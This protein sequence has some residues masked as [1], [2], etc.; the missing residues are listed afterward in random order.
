MPTVFIVLA[1]RRCLG[2]AAAALLAACARQPAPPAAAAARAAAASATAPPALAPV[3]SAYAE[4]RYLRDRFDITTATGQAA[5]PDGEPLVTLA[6]RFNAM[7]RALA[8][9][10]AAVDAGGLGA[11]DRRALDV[12]RGTFERDLGEL[13]DAP[14]ADDGVDASPPDCAYDARA[15]ASASNGL[16]S[17]TRRVYAC[18]GWAQHHVMLDGERMDR[19]TVLSALARTDDRARRRRLFL[20]LDPVWRSVNGDN[21][22]ASPFRQLVALA[23]RRRGAAEPPAAARA[24]GLGVHPDSMERWLLAMLETWRASTPDSLLEPWD[25]HYMGGRASRVLSPKLPPARLTNLN[26]EVFRALGADVDSLRVHY[27]LAPREGKTPVAFTTFGARAGP[28]GGAW[29]PAE[30]WVFATYRAGGLDN[31]NELLH[32]TGHA[33]HIAAVRTRPAF[34]DWPDS[35][36]FTEG[37]ADFIALDAYE[38]A[39]QQRWLGDSVP[40]ADGLRGRYA[41]V[42]LDVAWALFEVRMQRDP[43]ADPNQVWTAITRDYLKIRPHPELSWWAMRGQLVNSPGYMMNYAIGSILIAA[44][45]A[46]TRELHG[47]FA[48]GD[49]TWYAWVAPRLFRFGLER[50]SREVLEEFLGG[51]LSPTAILADM[52]RMQRMQRTQGAGTRGPAEAQP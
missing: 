25:W 38:P 41:G 19:L 37:L 7:R 2:V 3:E 29:A 42:V 31:L 21:G 16:D 22:A 14:T 43:G 8:P 50:P 10:L 49:P 5:S 4:L 46:R 51:P 28:R 52:Q 24:R 44:V 35:D 34:A 27:D 33:V 1:E 9:R 17:L 40:L 12:M 48:A 39:W 18:Y 15:V 26:A 30:P 47:P 23:A 13:S 36:P 45:R 6:H 20:A 32:E 11:E